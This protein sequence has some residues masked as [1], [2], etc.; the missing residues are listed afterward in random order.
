ME[1]RLS[2]Y[3]KPFLDLDVFLCLI[4]YKTYTGNIR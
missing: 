1:V 4:G 2:E 3:C